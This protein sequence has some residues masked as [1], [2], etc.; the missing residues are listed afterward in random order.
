MKQYIGTKLIEAVPAKRYEDEHEYAI[1]EDGREPTDAEKT[2]IKGAFSCKEGYRVR[3]ADGYESWSPKDVF[4]RA[5]LKPRTMTRSWART[6][7]WRR[8]RT[9]CGSC[10]ASCSRRQSTG[11]EEVLMKCRKKP[12]AVVAITFDDDWEIVE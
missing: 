12:V 1:I 3:Y 7:A 10:W 11:F 2:V 5:Y 6:S 9:R 8:S 4:E